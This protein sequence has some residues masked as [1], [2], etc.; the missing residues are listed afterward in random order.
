MTEEEEG[1]TAAPTA[2]TETTTTTTAGVKRE[3]PPALN[4]VRLTAAERAELGRLAAKR[5]ELEESLRSLERQLGDLE[6][7]YLETTT[8]E[9]TPAGSHK[10]TGYGG[11]LMRGWD[12]L[13]TSSGPAV[14]A[15]QALRGGRHRYGPYERIFSLSSVTSPASVAM[16]QQGYRP[17]AGS[18]HYGGSSSADA[19]AN[20]FYSSLFAKIVNSRREA[21]LLGTPAPD[22]P[23]AG[24]KTRSRRTSLAYALQQQQ[25]QQGQG[26]QQEKEQT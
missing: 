17:P 16:R 8:A 11:N 12:A 20:V 23:R 5:A 21:A 18:H 2:T 4:T 6:T 22:T 7:T 9:S 10:V 15:A 24:E 26:Q 25:Q 1:K 13:I 19:A 14:K 3:R